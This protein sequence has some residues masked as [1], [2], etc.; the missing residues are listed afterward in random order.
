MSERAVA[1]ELSLVRVF[2]SIYE[3]G[4]VSRAAALLELTQPAVSYSLALLRRQLGDPLF[5]RNRTGMSPTP[6][7]DKVYTAFRH[8]LETIDQ[9]C[10]TLST[11]DPRTSSRRFR[12]AMSDIGEMVYLPPLLAALR[13]E[14]AAISIEVLLVAFENTARALAVEQVD[15]AIGYL[16][17]VAAQTESASIFTERYVCMFRPGHPI[18]GKTLSLE[19]FQQCGHVMVS[20]PFSRLNVFVDILAEQFRHNMALQVVHFTSV[21]AIVAQT[22]LVVTLPS[23]VARIF[24]STHRLRTLPVPL[25]IPSYEVRLHWHARTAGDLG[26]QWMRELMVRVLSKL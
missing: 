11:F 25:K 14:A 17:G 15:F 9:A 5:M 6:L 3:A 10:N 1:I 21:P 12:I 20:S 19:K 7:A 2:C 24:A 8:G 4:S 18:I 26:H 16:P 22:D 13:A 23:R